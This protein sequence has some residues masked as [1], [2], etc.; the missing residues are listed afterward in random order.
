MKTYKNYTLGIGSIFLQLFLIFIAVTL[1]LNIIDG[2]KIHEYKL[3]KWYLIT[4]IPV[5][6][7]IGSYFDRY[8]GKIILDKNKLYINKIFY[9]LHI[10]FY[11]VLV[12]QEPYIMTINKV[13]YLFPEDKK[14]WT[15][16]NELYLEYCSIND[17]YF[18]KTDDIYEKLFVIMLELNEEKFVENTGRVIRRLPI[19]AVYFIFLKGL[20]NF[21]KKY[22]FYNDYFKIMKDLKGYIKEYKSNSGFS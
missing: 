1:L 16:L 14:F 12:I 2:I 18:G 20:I 6:F 5:I 17:E 21:I 13:I 4:I 8:Y 22:V 10:P 3:I 11:D 19:Y 9:N 15:E 7:L